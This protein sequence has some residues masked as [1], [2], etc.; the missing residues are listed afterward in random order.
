MGQQTVLKT[1]R[2]S[3]KKLFLLTM[4]LGLLILPLH[5]QNVW[6]SKIDTFGNFVHSPFNPHA[7]GIVS[8]LTPATAI[9][10]NRIQ[11][12]GI[13]G[14]DGVMCSPLAGIKVTDGTTTAALA[15]PNTTAT[16]G[17]PGP[18]TND[19]GPISLAFP[20]GDRLRLVAVPGSA[21]CNPFEI[22]IVVQYSVTP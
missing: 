3:V 10:V 12:Q 14:L 20:A 11:L 19:S 22:N 8:I 13:N 4:T 2:H 5:A 9:T 6:S 17:N 7:N 18:V 16:D 21:G 15:I 1:W